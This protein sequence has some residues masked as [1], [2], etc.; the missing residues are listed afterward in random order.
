MTLKQPHQQK[1]IAI[2]NMYYL[3]RD[4]SSQQI[5]T[6][7]KEEIG[8]HRTM[9]TSILHCQQRIECPALS[10]LVLIMR[11]R[12][13]LNSWQF[14]SLSFQGARVT[15]LP[16]HTWGNFLNKGSLMLSRWVLY[17]NMAMLLGNP[18]SLMISPE[19]FGCSGQRHLRS[20]PA[21]ALSLPIPVQPLHFAAEH[22][23][24]YKKRK[25]SFPN[26]PQR[27]YK[28]ICGQFV[29]MLPYCFKQISVPKVPGI[30]TPDRNDNNCHI[31]CLSHVHISAYT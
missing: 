5:L 30:W 9:E 29:I 17:N 26:V 28:V 10:V 25:A 27:D 15:D 6:S 16:F 31:S 23:T 14:L 24:G 3:T 11:P 18:C 4:R 20:P 19:W 22:P 8:S 13:T 12:L 1:D 7:L 2:I 21:L